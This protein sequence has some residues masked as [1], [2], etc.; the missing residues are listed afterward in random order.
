MP[1]LQ[2]NG[3]CYLLTK[4]KQ[5]EEK[6]K[7]EAQEGQKKAFQDH[8]LLGPNDVQLQFSL[9]LKKDFILEKTSE[10]PKADFEVLHPPPA[11]P[12]FLS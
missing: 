5:A 3:K 10:L 8:Y 7:K 2:C 12:S 6:Q 11:N 1:E 4:I 9:V